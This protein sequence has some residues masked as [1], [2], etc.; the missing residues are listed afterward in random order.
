MIQ[1]NKI[2][3]GN[4]ERRKRQEKD[5]KKERCKDVDKDRNGIIMRKKR[6]RKVTEE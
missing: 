2:N 4:E 5:E 1:K 3:H 6:L